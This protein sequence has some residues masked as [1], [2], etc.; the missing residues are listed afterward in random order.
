ME[1]PPKWIKTESPISIEISAL[2]NYS[3]SENK[4]EKAI[5]NIFPQIEL[6][7]TPENTIIGFSNTETIFFNFC[8]MIFD[9]KI[10]DVARKC[11]IEGI[12]TNNNQ[13][14]VNETIFFINK[15]IAYIN[16]VNFCEKNE[17]PLGPISISIK[18][19]DLQLLID[20]Y[21][22]KYEWF[23]GKKN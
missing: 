14:D 5:K 16:K 17:S 4:V 12:Q 9:Q 7:K 10:L 3:E 6:K 18:T 15:Q 21:F 1:Y 23:T 2:I 13:N 22:P 20:S 19:K 8:S 11:V